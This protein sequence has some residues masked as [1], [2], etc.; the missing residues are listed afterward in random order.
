MPIDGGGEWHTRILMRID[1]LQLLRLKLL[2]QEPQKM[3]RTGGPRMLA[4]LHL[5]MNRYRPGGLLMTLMPHRRDL[6]H[7]DTLPEYAD[8]DLSC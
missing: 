2:G 1:L 6:V 3:T 4:I 7:L 5:G 8:G